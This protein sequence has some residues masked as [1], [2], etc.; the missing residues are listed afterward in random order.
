MDKAN[1]AVMMIVGATDMRVSQ[2]RSSLT[3]LARV[4]M[5]RVIGDD[6][7][8]PGSE[9]GPVGLGGALCRRGAAS[10]WVSNHRTVGSRPGSPWRSLRGA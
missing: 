7:T 1:R 5:A 8:A 6:C 2:M 4:V 9:R 10:S 3:A